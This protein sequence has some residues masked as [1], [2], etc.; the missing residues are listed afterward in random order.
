MK[1]VKIFPKFQEHLLFMV[2]ST[3]PQNL[4]EAAVTICSEKSGC[5]SQE[6]FPKFKE[7]L[8]LMTAFKVYDMCREHG[9]SSSKFGGLKE[10]SVNV[11]GSIGG[12]TA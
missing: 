9:E 1:F 3:W 10:A 7:D 8:Y 6:S 2:T 5:P 12:G 11:C 4:Q